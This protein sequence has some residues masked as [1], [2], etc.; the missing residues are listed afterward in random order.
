LKRGKKNEVSVLLFHFRIS[1]FV[2]WYFALILLHVNLSVELQKRQRQQALANAAAG[3]AAG[4]AGMRFG[5]FEVALKLP[6]FC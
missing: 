1:C 3:G 2:C 5:L 6:L 4:V